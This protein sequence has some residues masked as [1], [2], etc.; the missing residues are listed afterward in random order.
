MAISFANFSYM[1]NTMKNM[2]LICVDFC[3]IK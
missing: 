2:N 1:E 3:Y